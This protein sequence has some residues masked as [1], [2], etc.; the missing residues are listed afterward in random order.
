MNSAALLR[1]RQADFTH[2]LPLYFS[3][4]L[5]LSI[6]A[7]K[8]KTK[9]PVKIQYNMLLVFFLT[10][11]RLFNCKTLALKSSFTAESPHTCV[12]V[13]G[14]FSNLFSSVYLKKISNRIEINS[15]CFVGFIF[16][17]FVF[18]LPTVEAA[19]LFPPNRR[20]TAYGAAGGRG[21]LATSRSH[22][23][24]MTGDFQLKKGELLHILVGQKGEDACPTVSLQIY[25]VFPR[26][27]CSKLCCLA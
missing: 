2:A 16:C 10:T 15:L 1:W 21:V 6:Q 24:Y 23:V 8:K 12:S 14:L 27:K 4:S 13:P 17:L 7:K 20:I 3:L 18:H 26:S 11:S 19:L 25:S 9:A 5:P 22:G